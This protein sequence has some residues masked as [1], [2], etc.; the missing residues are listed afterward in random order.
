MIFYFQTTVTDF[1]NIRKDFADLKEC[2][3]VLEGRLKGGDAWKKIEEE[4]KDLQMR[5]PIK[6]MVQRFT[7]TRLE[8]ISRCYIFFF[9]VFFFFFY[10][11]LFLNRN[12]VFFSSYSG[13]RVSRDAA[14]SQSLVVKACSVLS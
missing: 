1:D 11:F 2:S 12:P 8:K 9:I 5:I 7:S 13:I 6:N 4:L 14:F 3:A 10:F